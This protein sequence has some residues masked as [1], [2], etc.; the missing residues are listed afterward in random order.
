MSKI[1]VIKRVDITLIVVSIIPLVLLSIPLFVSATSTLLTIGDYMIILSHLFVVPTLHLTSRTRWLT[2][3]IGVTCGFS[4]IY[5][6]VKIANDTTKWKFEA[7]DEASQSMLI[8]LTTI[9]VLFDDMPHGGVAFLLIVGL[10]VSQFGEDTLGFTN[11]N[12][13]INSVAILTTITFILYRFFESRCKL[14]TIF[15]QEKR[16]WQCLI[17]GLTYF[18]VAFICYSESAATEYWRGSDEVIKYKYM[19]SMWHIC[20]YM[21][22][23]FIYKA[24]LD[25]SEEVLNTIRVK[26]TQFAIQ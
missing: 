16:R 18:L 20:A 22:L 25:L 6:F 10:I 21:A 17:I 23:Y 26:R 7:I 1:P 19:H 11:Y 14:D 12:I 9:L 8:W 3:I 13:F 5:H 15:F 24:R 4:A 2:Y